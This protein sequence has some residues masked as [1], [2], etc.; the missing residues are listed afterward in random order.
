MTGN[1][2]L[3]WDITWRDVGDVEKRR[4]YQRCGA[5]PL[6]GERALLAKRDEIS[7]RPSPLTG[8]WTILPLL[9]SSGVHL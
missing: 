9:F 8:R 2:I 6:L 5:T 4:L 3:I 1:I 7:D